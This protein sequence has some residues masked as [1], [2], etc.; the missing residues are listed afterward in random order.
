ML[1]I[2][3]Y[4]AKILLI[5]VKKLEN[6]KKSLILKLIILRFKSYFLFIAYYNFYFIV[7]ITHVY[8]NTLVG[9]L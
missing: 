8:L 4:L 9:L 3:S 5:L 2:L 6:L 7:D 1:K